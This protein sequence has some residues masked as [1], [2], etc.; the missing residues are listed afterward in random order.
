MASES[1]DLN[2]VAA[3]KRRIAE[4][5]AGA[6]S[7]VK[8][9]GALALSGATAVGAKGLNI[10]GSNSAAIIANSTVVQNYFAQGKPS[11]TKEQISVQ[12]AAYLL[13]V[14]ARNREIVLRGIEKAGGG[15]VVILPLETAYVA[16]RATPPRGDAPEFAM[17]L[18]E[19]DRPNA[20]PKKRGGKRAESNGEQTDISL[21]EVLSLGNRLAVIGGPGSGKTTVLMHMA[22]ALAASLLSGQAEPARSRLGITVEPGQLPLPVFVPLASFARYLRDLT[23]NTPAQQRTLAFFISHHLISKQADFD[24]PEDFFVQLLRG[25]QDVLLLLDGLDEVANED[26]RAL[27]RQSV[28]EL[29]SGRPHMRVLV[30]CR[31]IAYRGIRTALAADFKEITVQ[32]LDFDAHIVPMVTQAYACIHPEDKVRRQERTVDLLNGIA[33]LERVRRARLGE[34]ASNLADSPLMVRLLLIVHVSNATLPNQRSELFEKAVNALL[35]VDYGVEVSNNNELK[36]DWTQFRDMAQHLAYV[37][38]SAGEEAGREIDESSLKA[39]LN[40]EADFK[41]RIAEFLLHARNRGSLLEERDGSFRFIHLAFQEFLVAR[42]LHEIVGGVGGHAAILAKLSANFQDPWWR[43]PILLLFGHKAA[44]APSPANDFIELVSGAGDTAHSQFAAAELAG[45]GALEWKN[46]SAALRQQ[47]ALRIVGLLSHSAAL[48]D[49]PAPVRALAGETLSQLGDPRF[50][51]NRLH[52]PADADHG[53]VHIKPDASFRVGTRSADRARVEAATGK[54]IFED[55]VNDALTPTQA[56]YIAKF[57]VTVAQFKA[58]LQAT[59]PKPVDPDALR[60][61]D[62]RPVRWVNWHE[63]RAYCEW[64]TTEL[65]G[66]QVF[67]ESAIAR[68]VREEAWTVELPTEYEWEKAAR[69]GLAGAV[70]SWGDDIDPQRANYDDSGVDNTSAVGC[71]PS[72]GY[73]LHDMLGNVWQWTGS[74]YFDDSYKLPLSTGN[75]LKNKDDRWVVRGGSWNVSADGAR[76]AYRY[77]GTADDRYGGVGFRVVLRSA[78]V[79]VALRS[80][81]SEL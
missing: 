29:V 51:V 5:E 22:W 27:V 61:A 69:G 32:P 1:D 34:R 6:K 12:V 17:R 53:F 21:S 78:P 4:L 71:F 57:P 64:L 2:E 46:S 18:D 26:E 74:A 19:A 48:L 3:L 24:L 56:F 16:L 33:E 77:G 80:G 67:N 42:Y 55:E 36:S 49:T 62:L 72:N 39:A 44:A 20:N 63:A 60:D 75:A 66:S 14:Q 8:G 52:L 50:D 13:W 40:S 70:F 25:G 79:P 30:T 23:R 73:G 37:M 38:H 35:Q 11:L 43:E 9:S 7:R 81:S 31:S 65:R 54:A 41:P 76:C 10:A 15:S 59:G 47:L 58:Y 28:E 68:L 45:T